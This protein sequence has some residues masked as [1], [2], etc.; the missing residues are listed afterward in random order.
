[1]KNEQKKVARN[2]RLD[3]GLN[4]ELEETA[5]VSG[6]PQTTIVEDSLRWYLG[7]ASRESEARRRFVATIPKHE[8]HGADA[9]AV[10]GL[11]LLLAA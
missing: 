4:A 3:A 11:A 7:C 10:C 2:F 8:A 5:S 6:I 9:V 1:M